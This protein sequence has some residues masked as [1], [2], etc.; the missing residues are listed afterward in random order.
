MRKITQTSDM[1][2]R[3][4]AKG[5]TVMVLAGNVTAKVCDIA[6]EYDNTAFVCLRAAHQP[7]SRGVWHAA[8]Q[9]MWVASA[10]R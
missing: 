6:L 3:K 9:V 1:G 7:F 2:G 5:D 4:L 8:D 10:R